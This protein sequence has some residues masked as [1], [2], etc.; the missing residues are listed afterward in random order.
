[1]TD[2]SKPLDGRLALVTGASRGIGYAV[3]Q[4][5]LQDGLRVTLMGRDQ[6][7]LQKAVEN[8]A[9][10]GEVAFVRGDIAMQSEVRQAFTAGKAHFGV[11]DSLV[12]NT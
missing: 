11:I 5:L 6:Q 8:L 1:M 12:N 10:Y 9:A 4:R 7:S 2:D 3:A